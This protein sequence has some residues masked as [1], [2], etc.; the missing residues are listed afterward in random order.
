MPDPEPQNEAF[1]QPARRQHGHVPHRPERPRWLI[2]AFVLALVLALAFAGHALWVVSHLDGGQNPV[3]GWMT[4]GYVIHAYSV[5]PEVLAQVLG[6]DPGTARGRTL[7]DIA[8]DRGI[9]VDVLIA[10]VQAVVPP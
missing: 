1:P 8:A 3:Q 7:D 10:A 2:A 4:P 6:I 5:P 9:P